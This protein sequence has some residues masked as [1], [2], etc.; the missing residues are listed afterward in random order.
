MVWALLHLLTPLWTYVHYVSRTKTANSALLPMQEKA[1]D[2]LVPSELCYGHRFITINGRICD[3]HSGNDGRAGGVA[4]TRGSQEVTKVV[5]RPIG[6]IHTPF[7]T[8]GDMPI[9]PRG[10]LGVQGTVE[11]L[12]EFHAAL[13]DLDGFS[14]LI[15]LY[16]LHRVSTVKLRVIPFLDTK[17]R[18]VF[19][20]RAPVRP[21]PIGL[22]V[23]RLRSVSAGTLDVENVDILDG[24]PL[25]DIKPYVPDFDCFDVDCIGWY[26]SSGRCLQERRSDDRFG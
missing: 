22:S 4:P 18:G 13:A 20:T 14:H 19:A 2:G 26:A 1:L 11:V 6:V 25:L 3:P 7:L 8:I 23:V 24:T 17:E 21:N 5:Y 16:H 9:Q 10:A 12:P 15:L